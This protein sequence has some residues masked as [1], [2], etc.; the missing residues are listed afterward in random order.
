MTAISFELSTIYELSTGTGNAL[1]FDTKQD[2]ADIDFTVEAEEDNF[3]KEVAKF[4]FG[5]QTHVARYWKPKKYPANG[6]VF[7][8][9]GYA[10]Y[11]GSNYEELANHLC[12]KGNLV[13]GHDHVGHGLTSGCRVHVNNIDDY[14][15][16]VV[17]HVE[18]VKNWPGH[19][20]L[21]TY[22]IGHSMGGL[23]SLF[24][25]FKKQELFNGFIG[26]GP[27]LE[28]SPVIATPY[29]RLLAR[30]LERTFPKML[31]S[32]MD[33]RATTRDRA[34]VARNDAD[35]LIWQGGF[36]TR[37]SYVMMK[38][39]EYA[40]RRLGKITLPLLV[41]QGGKDRLGSP[42]EAHMIVDASTSTDKEYK[43][44][45][46]A[47]HALHVELVVVKY[48]VFCKIDNW[49]YDR[50]KKLGERKKRVE[51]KESEA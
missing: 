29:K 39:C 8:C 23:I 10:E 17:A 46:G 30:A 25:L 44:Y 5:T 36:R 15:E 38:S 21:S 50:N 32:R 16:P 41:L 31:F 19:K 42:D 18:A 12:E 9:H 6:L 28:V 40:K 51:F 14:V 11:V 22:L 48:D 47:Y 33:S 26:I 37:H 27:L 34:V 24:V 20:N 2:S 45:P 1:K 13:F 49:I 7:L 35:P 4:S 3:T 43:E